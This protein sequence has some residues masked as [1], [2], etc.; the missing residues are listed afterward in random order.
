MKASEVHMLQ[1]NMINCIWH[2]YWHRSRQ[3]D[4]RSSGFKVALVHVQPIAQAQNY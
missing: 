2:F 3:H 4:F 1:V